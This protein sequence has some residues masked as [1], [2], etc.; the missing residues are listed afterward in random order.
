MLGGSGRDPF[1]GMSA[2]L[3][4]LFGPRCLCPP[5]E[6]SKNTRETRGPARRPPKAAKVIKAAAGKIPAYIRGRSARLRGV[7]AKRRKRRKAG[8]DQGRGSFGEPGE[9]GRR[10][11]VACDQERRMQRRVRREAARRRTWV[12]GSQIYVR[13]R[14]SADIGR[15]RRTIIRRGALIWGSTGGPWTA[16]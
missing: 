4:C 8:E 15:Y 1:L 12:P 9:P 2:E 10:R 11:A 7:R 5:L 3:S 14:G 6:I 13:T 16:H